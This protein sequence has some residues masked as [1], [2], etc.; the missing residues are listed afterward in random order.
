M[1]LLP[2][3]LLLDHRHSLLSFLRQMNLLPS[4]LLKSLN[5]RQLLLFPLPLNPQTLSLMSPL[6]NFSAS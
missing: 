5:F 1:W 2:F 3:L 4:L 6:S